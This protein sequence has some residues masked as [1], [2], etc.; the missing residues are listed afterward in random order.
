[1]DHGKMRWSWDVGGAFLLDTRE[2]AGRDFL[3]TV[4]GHDLPSI[5]LSGAG[6]FGPLGTGG[7]RIRSVDRPIHGG[8][9]DM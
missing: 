4:R 3:G 6:L 2:A 1:M 9:R 8:T 7:G 5:W